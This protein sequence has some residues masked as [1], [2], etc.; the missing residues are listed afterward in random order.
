MLSGV[1]MPAMERCSAC[2]NDRQASNTCESCHRNLVLLVPSDH[3]QSG[4]LRNH[5]ER[6]RLGEFE[7]SCQMCHA[8]TYCQ[9]CHQGVGLKAFG[10]G[11]LMSDPAPRVSGKDS[12]NRIRLQNVHELGYRFTHGIDAKSRRSE[13][14]SCHSAQE[15]C[16]Q[17]HEAGGN[18]N[19]AGFK[20]A[21]HSVPGF[22]GV[23]RGTGGGLHAEEARRDM[24]SCI[25][26]HD[27][28]G[29]D[30]TCLTCHTE[31]GGVR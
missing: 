15:F 25:S 4:F 16:V 7:A 22:A 24:E 11:E 12:P 18:I 2:H 3:R 26:C 31:G 13:C 14:A 28:E 9:E 29:R 19:Q 30:P 20:P 10:P 6:V 17:C 8:E 21:S 5:R 27:V 23:G 1:K